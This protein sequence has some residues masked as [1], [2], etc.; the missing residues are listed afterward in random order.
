MLF[1]HNLCFNKG[2]RAVGEGWGDVRRGND[3][4]TVYAILKKT[5]VC[6]FVC[7]ECKNNNRARQEQS[8]QQPKMVPRGETEEIYDEIQQLAG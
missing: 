4:E 5:Y 1:S 2:K 3:D 6:R 8:Q 7:A